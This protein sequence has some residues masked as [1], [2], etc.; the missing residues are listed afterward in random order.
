MITMMLSNT[1][2]FLLALLKNCNGDTADIP[3]KA[4][5]P[6]GGRLKYQKFKICFRNFYLA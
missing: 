3:Q 6:V 5:L 2:K 4:P 1:A